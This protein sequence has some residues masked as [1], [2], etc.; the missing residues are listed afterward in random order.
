[1][2]HSLPRGAAAAAVAALASIAGAALADGATYVDGV[3]YVQ[4]SDDAVALADVRAGRLDA[5][6][7][8]LS[9]SLLGPGQREGVR[10]HESSS[11]S[12][13]L[14]VNPAEGGRL[15]PFSDRAARQALNHMIDR[16]LVVNE[17][18]GGHGTPMFSAYA[19]HDPDY[20]ALAAAG[21]PE[22]AY[23]P[24]LA[25]EMLSRSLEGAGARLEGGRWEHG[26]ENVRTTVF[27]RGDD[28]ARKAIGELLALELERTG[29]TVDREYGDLS[30]ALAVVYGS[31][32]A[33]LRWGVYTE[34]WGGRAAFVRYDP[35]IL[36]QMYAPWFSSMPGFNDP[37]YWNYRNATVDEL[38][39][40]IYA[41]GFSGPEERDGMVRA[42]AR[43]GT[44]EA[45][46]VFLAARDDLYAVGE[47]VEGVVNGFGAGVPSRFTAIN[48]QTPSGH[49]RVGVK[50]AYQGSWNPVM[51]FG[52]AYSSRI[53]QTLSD[54]AVFRNPYSG[55]PMPVRASW[56]VQTGGP[57]PSIAV[58]PEAVLWDTASQSW[59]GAPGGTLAASAIEYE[60]S[61]SRWHHGEMMDMNDVM[62]AVY[63]AQE[64]GSEATPADVTHDAEY[65]SRAAQLVSALRGVEALGPDRVRVYVDYWHFDEAE[66]AGWASV[67][68]QVPWEVMAGMER[69]VSAGEAS[70]SR[71]GAAAAG[72]PWLSLAIPSDAGLVGRH[73][74]EM[75]ASG[76]VP[77][78]MSQ[79]GAGEAYA[80]QRY[81]AALGWIAERGHAVVSNGPYELV[82]YTPESR[83]I[84]TAA[85]RDESYPFAR[86]HWLHLS[87]VELP[88]ITGVGLPRAVE[89]GA[90]LEVRVDAVGATLVSYHVEAPGA[91]PLLSGR[92]TVEGGAAAVSLSAAETA[93]LGGG[94]HTLRL[95]A[96][97]DDV[98]RPDTYSSGFMVVDRGASLPEAA[99]AGGAGGGERAE[100]QL[101]AAATVAAAAAA[102][103]ALAA[104]ARLALRRRGSR[105]KERAGLAPPPL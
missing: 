60:L 41:G 32:P 28:L 23:D 59:K 14:L 54:P 52:D 50:Q 72:V 3:T 62:H 68:P 74:A 84:E 69:A 48:A 31:D 88:R 91:G 78:A 15:N 11:G 70:F 49:M 97:S 36:A 82:A 1:M 9:P 57:E 79:L 7:A 103:A 40:A 38:T 95:F 30:K 44:E 81:A 47:G 16:S 10:V 65:A 6:Y 89:A 105:D 63:F 55:S 73:V 12:Y 86:G 100:P 34:G 33:E 26:G 27:I 64:W 45:V 37:L 13:S 43:I 61:M 19:P 20:A 2:C 21:A 98:L 96:S 94:A 58:P 77:A 17:V 75:A 93:G 101:A 66:I 87:G 104:W 29:I 102:V 83:T 67:W 18:L 5:H 53:W 71:S 85:T 51:G 8:G 25:R 35:V 76:H 4:Y 22:F 39:R 92:A 90:P 80:Q 42:A 99:A 46:R 56:E 24:A